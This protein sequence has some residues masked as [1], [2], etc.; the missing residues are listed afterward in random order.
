[1]SEDEKDIGYIKGR[2]D[3]MIQSD[4]NRSRREEEHQ[5][6]IKVE[7]KEIKKRI[8]EIEKK[9]NFIYAWAAGVAAAMTL[10]IALVRR[11]WERI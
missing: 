8:H 7:L 6:S 1:M 9:V 5:R 11:Y 10:I 3:A 2:I 4:K